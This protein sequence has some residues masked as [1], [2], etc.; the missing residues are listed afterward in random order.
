MI[1]TIAIES[2]RSLKS[3]VTTVDQ[4]TVV[5]GANGSGKTNFYRAL[6]LLADVVRDGAI[7]T[8]AAEGGMPSALYAGDRSESQVAMRLGFASDQFSYAIDLGQPAA[9]PFGLDPQIKAEAVWMGEVLLPA[10]ALAE[11]RGPMVRT[12]GADGSWETSDWRLGDHDSMMSALANPSRTPE[13]FI[14]REQVRGWRFYDHFRTDANAAARKPSVATFT[15][16]LSSGGGDLAAALATI[17]RVG[18]AGALH[19]AVSEAFGGAEL[20]LRDDDDGTCRIALQQSGVKRPL[21]AREL[22]DG[23]LRFLLLAAVLL[24]PRPPGLLVL[25]E[26]ESS[27]HSGLMTALAK[28]IVDA[29]KRSQI[30]VVTHSPDLVRCLSSDARLIEL[31]KPNGATAISG[32]SPNEGP[33]W[34]WPER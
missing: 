15:P 16:V 25:N 22:S 8:L 3:V 9:G 31:E 20:L 4:L 7:S 24:S 28:L 17:T 34:I 6:R 10:T 30:V 13:L 23:T 33:K 5:T 1:R 29:A 19:R 12:R 18:L 11:R 32:Q 21:V 2:Y 27:L 26:P 14:I